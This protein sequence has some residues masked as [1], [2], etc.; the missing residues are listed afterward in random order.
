MRKI[1]ITIISLLLI[2]LSI[3][4]GM[5]IANSNKKGK[6]TFNKIVSTVYTTTIEN[7]SIPVIITASGSLTAKNKIEL[8]SE[9]QGVL[10]QTSKN[11][12]AGTQYVKNETIIALNS[13]EFYANLK[14]QKSN[15]FNAITAI[16]PDIQLDYSKEYLKWKSYLNKFDINNNTPKL[17]E[18]NSEKEKFF[19]SGRGIITN[20]YNVKN[21]EVKL[22]KYTLK[23]PF[24][25]ILTE[26]MVTQGSLVR[27]GQKLG[28]Y[29]DPSVYE[30]EVNINE[31]SANLLKKG[32]K[33]TIYNL[34]KTNSWEA[35]VVRVNGKIDQATQTVKTY[36]Q[37]KGNQLREGMY[38]TADLESKS[39]EN[40]IE[41][42]RKL[43]VD[44]TKLFTVK[45]SILNLVSINPVYFNDNTVILQGLENGTTILSKPLPGAYNG[46]L[47]KTIN[48]TNNN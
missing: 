14:A 24:N 31:T 41:I 11:F 39:I 13:D 21:L 5:A 10:K 16:M 43:L 36:L 19:I 38:L 34:N 12:K 46:M 2:A 27:V 1:I 22:A 47:V 8:F 37:V 25:G 48:E 28:E 44:D 4:G 26:A 40:A 15:L 30:M 42:S 23:A 6:P 18:T 35:T 29:I 9:V 45:D 7:K 20:Y 3:I 32:T 33:V 17:P